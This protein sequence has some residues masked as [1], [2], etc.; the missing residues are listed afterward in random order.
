MAQ[1]IMIVDDTLYMRTV[2][3]NILSEKGFT[4]VEAANGN[5]AIANCQ[6]QSPD[7]ILMDI[8]M[9]EMDGIAATKA[10]CDSVPE[11]KVV[12]CSA[13]GQ[14]QMVIEATEA[15]ALDYIT[16]PFNPSDVLE[17]VERNLAA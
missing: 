11:A 4:I 6:A 13:L 3:K 7:L 16:K 1:T 12:I 2:L 17:A 8:T 14:Q 10:I 15:G 9:P 5:E